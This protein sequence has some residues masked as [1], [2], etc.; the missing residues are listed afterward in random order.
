[1][2]GRLSYLH[3]FH[4]C[5]DG[6]PLIQKIFKCINVL[7]LTLRGEVHGEISPL[8]ATHI[9]TRVICLS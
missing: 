1:M 6:F 9:F 4:V 5:Y 8:I 7:T 3:I 2:R